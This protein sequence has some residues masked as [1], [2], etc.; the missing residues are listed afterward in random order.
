MEDKVTLYI[1]KHEKYYCELNP[2]AK[3]PEF[4]CAWGKIYTDK[5]NFT[6]HQKKCE[7]RVNS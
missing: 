3:K 7:L 4:K 6:P 2:N 5:G 1:A